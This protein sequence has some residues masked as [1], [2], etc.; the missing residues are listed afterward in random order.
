MDARTGQVPAVHAPRP[1]WV[2]RSMAALGVLAS[3]AVHLVEWFGGYRDIPWVGGLFLLNSVAGLVLAVL[4]VTWRHWLPLVGA[5]GL[6]A[7]TL[8]AFV[9]STTVGF[10]GVTS[11][12]TG[13]TVWIAATA[14]VLAVVAATAAL[15]REQSR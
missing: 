5:V 8:L 13:E 12:F 2:W 9:A 7:A 14:E 3:A 15:L 1:A 6:G 11:R 10:L 4:L